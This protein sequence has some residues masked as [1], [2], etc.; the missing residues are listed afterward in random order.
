M[1]YFIVFLLTFS[2]NSLGLLLGSITTDAKTVSTLTPLLVIPFILFS[3]F[4]KNNGN[5]PHWISWLAYIS[6]IKY[7]F[8]ALIEN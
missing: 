2:G 1:F 4:F 6:P 5:L 8:A 7:G 3:G